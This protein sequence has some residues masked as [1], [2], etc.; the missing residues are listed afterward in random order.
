MK[1]T[2]WARNWWIAAVAAVLLVAAA[3]V[4]ATQLRSDTAAPPTTT[5]P[6]TTVL[7]TTAASAST[8]TPV[9]VTGYQLLWP[10]ADDKQAAAWQASYREGGHSPWHLDADL[11][12]QSFAQ[13]Y[14]G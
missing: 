12:A 3:V 9:P 4:V 8:T 5:A 6:M 1:T 11:T 10:F 2:N 13:G 14:L 7:T